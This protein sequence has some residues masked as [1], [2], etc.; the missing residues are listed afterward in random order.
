MGS[1]D[2]KEI[3]SRIIFWGQNIRYFSKKHYYLTV[4]FFLLIVTIVFTIVFI[5]QRREIERKENIVRSFYQEENLNGQEGSGENVSTQE[6]IAIL[7][8][9]IC[10]EVNDPGVYEIEEGSRIMDL[11]EIG[12]GQ[13]DDAC[14]DALNLA[15]EILDGQRVYVPSKQEIS[16]GT[17]TDPDNGGG[18]SDNN[19]Y[20]GTININSAASTLLEELPGIGP[21]IAGNIIEHRG[22]YG[23]FENIE[24]LLDVSGIGPKKFERIRDL[25]DV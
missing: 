13:T 1:F 7:K 8:A 15:Q 3:F 24:Q 6:D 23:P 25:I 18:L 5:N 12:G 4:F 21:V 16:D 9:H 11:I 22:K 2:F 17:Y 14:L 10:G 19:G 20:D